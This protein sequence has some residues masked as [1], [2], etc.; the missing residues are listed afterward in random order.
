[1]ISKAQFSNKSGIIQLLFLIFLCIIGLF[2]ASF[3][4]YPFISAQQ[5][6]MN[7]RIIQLIS[8]IGIF[9]FPA[10]GIAWL[11]SNNV[12]EY[13]C[14]KKFPTINIFLLVTISVFLISP[15]ISLTSYFNKQISLPEFMLPIEQWMI[16]KEKIAIDL[17]EM[18]LN[19]KGLIAFISNI[20]V[21]AVAAA[22]T[23]EFLFR[24]T[25]SQIIQKCTANHHSTIWVTA[26][27]FSAIHLQFYGFVPRMLL[28]AYLG[29]LIYWSKNIWLPI[30]AHFVNNAT[31]IVVMSNPSMKNEDFLTGEITNEHLLG[32]SV[33]TVICTTLFFLVASK[34]KKLHN[35]KT[36][37]L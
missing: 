23:E 1:M 4:A 25:L 31:T 20:I 21:V 32:F 24:G 13:L 37:V 12:C 36:E 34:I 11:C 17:T 8:S 29:Y 28:G 33:M 18:L 6:P 19:E 15:A 26:I 22:F 30:L 10:I 14:F 9:L 16:E 7:L 5:T 3:F 27:I 35:V 2:L